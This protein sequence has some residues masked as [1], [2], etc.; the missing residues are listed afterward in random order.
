MDV[1]DNVDE[2]IEKYNIKY[3]AIYKNSKLTNY[4]IENDLARVLVE[5]EQ[6]ILLEHK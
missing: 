5:D 1:Q 4:L 6:Y 3:Y 2:L